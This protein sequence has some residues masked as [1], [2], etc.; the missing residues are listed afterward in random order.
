MQKKK[1]SFL[2]L[3]KKKISHLEVC[4]TFCECDIKIEH[5]LSPQIYQFVK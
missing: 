5:D 4:K 1:T 2:T 3:K